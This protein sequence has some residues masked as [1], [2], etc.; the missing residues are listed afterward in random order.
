VLPFFRWV[1]TAQGSPIK[2]NSEIPENELSG[3]FLIF[4][5]MSV[6]AMAT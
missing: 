4:C 5:T 3:I 6:T 1:F 2:K